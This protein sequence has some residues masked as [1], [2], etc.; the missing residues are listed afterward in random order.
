MVCILSLFFGGT[1]ASADELLVVDEPTAAQDHPATALA[2]YL[3]K[4]DASYRWKKIRE[5]SISGVSYA[6]LILTSQTWQNIVWNHRLFILKPQELVDDKNALLIVSGGSWKDEFADE[7]FAKTPDKRAVLFAKLAQQMNAPVA[8]LLQ[9]PQQPIFDGKVE[10]QIISYTFEKYLETGDAEWPL[11]LPMV[12]SAMR[13]MDAVQEFCQEEWSLPIDSFT[14]TGA[15][16][17]GW[18]TWLTGAMDPRVHGIAPMVIDLLN[19]QAQ[20]EHQLETWGKFSEN[21]RD[22]TERRI[23]E[24]MRTPRGNALTKI[25]DPLSYRQSLTLPKLI[26]LGTNDR[27]WTLDALNLYWNK[28]QGSK[29]V[30]YVPNNRHGLKDLPRVMGSISALHEHVRGGEKLPQLTWDFDA[31]SG[32]LS[33]SSDV[34][35]SKCQIW[36]AVTD[37]HDFR[38]SEWTATAANKD[39]DGYAFD[40]EVPSSG[41]QAVFGEV[42]YER[43][44]FP[45]HL[46][47]NVYIVE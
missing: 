3:A 40:V 20:M 10:D 43:E 38:D 17:R 22:Y 39:G 21:I 1:N 18:T 4:A 29:Y 16:K 19:M 35:P 9:V 31:S 12:K 41:S 25:V 30:L 47:T 14:V 24:R 23:Q 45:L 5:G 44:G 27:F 46:S 6:E 34:P 13:G 15:S 36:S 37:N 11:L 28:L 32:K 8:V 42:I 26:I 7:S 33:I 2:D